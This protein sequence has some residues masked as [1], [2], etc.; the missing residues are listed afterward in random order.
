MTTE[1]SKSAT[2]ADTIR[3]YLTALSVLVACFSSFAFLFLVPFVID[4]A[5]STLFAEYHEDPVACVTT[6]AERKSGMSNCTWSSCREGC[7][8][9]IF[10]CTQIYV[11][12]KIDG[13]LLLESNY[14]DPASFF[15]IEWDFTEAKLFPNVKGCGYPPDVNCS[16]FD[17]LFSSIGATFPCYYSKVMEDTALTKAR[18]G[19]S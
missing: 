10:Q 19:Q 16:E 5:F 11:N 17:H 1:D 6:I 9:D 13:K 15:N 18:L 2:I 7:T 4:P 3:F 8:N 14:T 12:Y